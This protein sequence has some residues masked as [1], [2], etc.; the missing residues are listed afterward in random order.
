MNVT[1]YFSGVA[2]MLGS[3]VALLV[4]GPHLLCDAGRNGGTVH[5]EFGAFADS[6]IQRPDQRLPGA[7][8]RKLL[9]AELAVVGADGPICRSFCR[10][11]G[12]SHLAD[13]SSA[14]PREREGP[15]RR[16]PHGG[17]PESPVLGLGALLRY[18]IQVGDV[19]ERPK[20]QHSKCCLV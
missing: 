15:D 3:L 4:R 16:G 19:S 18:P 5:H 10:L 1:E 9:G 11:L 14:R 17:R 13:E 7:G 20:V 12:S 6:R 2:I 8:H